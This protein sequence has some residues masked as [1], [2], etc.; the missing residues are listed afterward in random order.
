MSGV[1][2]AVIT[3]S[4]ARRARR[5]PAAD[6][7]ECDGVPGPDELPVAYPASPEMMRSMRAP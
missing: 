2:I 3:G 5:N 1:R 4:A 7:G 6:G